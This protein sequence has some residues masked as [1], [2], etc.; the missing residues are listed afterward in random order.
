[1]GRLEVSG[2]GSGYEIA[3]CFLS[4]L[5]SGECRVAFGVRETRAKMCWIWYLFCPTN[6]VGDTWLGRRFG[7]GGSVIGLFGGFL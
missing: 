1:M 4:L 5:W 7:V 3:P 2:Y 6:S